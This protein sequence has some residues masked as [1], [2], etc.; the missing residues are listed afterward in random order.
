MQTN[1]QNII[2]E[3]LEKVVIAVTEVTAVVLVL[4]K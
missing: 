4:C 2:V 1:R 3:D